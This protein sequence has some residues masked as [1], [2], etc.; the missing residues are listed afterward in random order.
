V[1]FRSV[2]KVLKMDILLAE[3][4]SASVAY[5]QAEQN[6]IDGKTSEAIATLNGIVTT[7]PRSP[8]A[9]KALYTIGWLYENILVSNDTASQWYAR[10]EKEY[11]GSVYAEKVHPKLAIKADPKAVSQYVKVKEIIP[12]QKPNA[13]RTAR[14]LNQ[15]KG[16][17]TP[18]EQVGNDR[19]ANRDEDYE[20][21][22]DDDEDD[23]TTDE[24][25]DNN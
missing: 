4:D 15:Q 25:D 13:P 7:Y 16:K 12:I 18:Q 1:L 5:R 23:S 9:P 19:N 17:G 14:T 8:L 21:N 20:D 10:V 6:I 11:P 3:G 24:P 2:R 22:T